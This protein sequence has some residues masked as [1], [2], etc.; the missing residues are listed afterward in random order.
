M[1]VQ[2]VEH[3][4]GRVATL[5]DNL[6]RAPLGAHAALNFSLSLRYY[7]DRAPNYDE[8]TDPT[9][10]RPTFHFTACPLSLASP[11]FDLECFY[12][13]CLPYD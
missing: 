9:T 2:Q 1:D 11:F 6:G 4:T 10:D 8:P 7:R 5:R 12:L 13:Y 3:D